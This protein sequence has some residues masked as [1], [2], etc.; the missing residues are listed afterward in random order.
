MVV[1]FK[2]FLVFGMLVPYLL[3]IGLLIRLHARAVKFLTYV[4]APAIA[5][6]DL[7]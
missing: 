4:D 2:V 1:Q 3:A 6:Y 7:D 5:S